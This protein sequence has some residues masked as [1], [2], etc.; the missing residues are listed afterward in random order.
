MER[1]LLIEFDIQTGKRAGNISPRDPK[2]RC[3]GWQDLESTP[4]REIRMIEDDRDLS[5]YEGIAG[6]T[7]LKGKEEINEAIK[8][9]IPDKYQIT[10]KELL[11]E[12]M[13][14]NR[15]S[16]TSL[17]NFDQPCLKDLFNK[18]LAGVIRRKPE[19]LS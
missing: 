5:Q 14:E 4:A 18:G 9:E 1:A 19:C 7:I 8:R 3:S 11:F 12:S 13:R 10:D 17:R 16:F 6:I 15:M 2:L